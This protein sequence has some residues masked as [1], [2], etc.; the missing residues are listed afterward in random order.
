MLKDKNL[1]LDLDKDVKRSRKFVAKA[2][3]DKTILK[4]TPKDII[5]LDL[6]VKVSKRKKMS[7]AKRV[8]K[9]IMQH[10][11]TGSKIKKKALDNMLKIETAYAVNKAKLS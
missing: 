6:T 5:S 11:Q 7:Q 8:E 10:M 2:L 1:L 9:I 4:L 3:A